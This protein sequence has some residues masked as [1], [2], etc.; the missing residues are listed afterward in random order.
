MIVAK[1]TFTRL[2]WGWLAGDIMMLMEHIRKDGLRG[3]RSL[4][5]GH[6]EQIIV[7]FMLTNIYNRIVRRAMLEGQYLLPRERG[8]QRLQLGITLPEC[9]AISL[10][11]YNLGDQS[12]RLIRIATDALL[13]N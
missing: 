2:E 9:A 4:R 1:V 11:P 3:H 12:E 10:L 6:A 8:T 13:R 5:D 7:L